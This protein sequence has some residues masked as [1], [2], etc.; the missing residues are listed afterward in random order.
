MYVCEFSS[1][2]KIPVLYK[3]VIVHSTC[4]ALASA[5]I[6]ENCPFFYAWY[7]VRARKFIFLNN[8][9]CNVSFI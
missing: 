1:F 9:F 8:T 2:F 6:I 4:L 7:R 3:G 5:P